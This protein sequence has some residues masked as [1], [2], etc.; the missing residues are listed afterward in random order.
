VYLSNFLGSWYYFTE[1]CFHVGQAYANIIWKHDTVLER[2]LK[3]E[4]N[5]Q[6]FSER[7]RSCLEQ[8]RPRPAW[9]QTTKHQ[10]STPY[11]EQ[12]LCALVL[13]YNVF[14]FN[15]PWTKKDEGV[16]IF[17]KIFSWILQNYKILKLKFTQPFF[18]QCRRPI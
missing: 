8:K 9:L 4:R 11:D 12:H 10:K 15:T 5:S 17:Y 14:S 16:K 6:N 13:N 1:H 7:R 2:K 18:V 3:K